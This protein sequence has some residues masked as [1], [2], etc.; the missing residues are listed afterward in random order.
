MTV[1]LHFVHYG[2]ARVVTS[3]AC[4]NVSSAHACI[5]ML[6][7]MARQEAIA[8]GVEDLLIHEFAYF[9][10]ADQYQPGTQ[11]DDEMPE[12]YF[13]PDWYVATDTQTIPF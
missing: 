7:R 4:Q 12:I 8:S 3:M 2:S 10:L 11:L 9:V 13:E 1:Y 6:Q 5:R